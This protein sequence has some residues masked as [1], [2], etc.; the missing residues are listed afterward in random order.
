MASRTAAAGDRSPA[1]GLGRWLPG[2]GNAAGRDGGFG[3]PRRVAAGARVFDLVVAAV[4]LPLGAWLAG[5]KAAP[6]SR[7]GGTRREI[8]RPVLVVL[9]AVVGCVGST[10]IGGGSTLAPVL[11]GSGRPAFEVA[12]AALA[13]TFVTSVGW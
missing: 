2:R 9:S 3:D 8:P 7:P 1:L 12:P 5:M 4:L 13:S 6:A 11:I 10:G